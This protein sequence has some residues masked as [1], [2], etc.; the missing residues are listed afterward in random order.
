MLQTGH[1]SSQSIRTKQYAVS[2]STGLCQKAQ[3]KHSG[4]QLAKAS[5][6]HTQREPGVRKARHSHPGTRSAVTLNQFYA[7]GKAAHFGTAFFHLVPLAVECSLKV[8]RHGNIAAVAGSAALSE[9]SA[10]NGERGS[11]LIKR[12]TRQRYWHHSSLCFSCR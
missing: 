4:V 2:N 6:Q 10:H 1:P 5:I 8:F 12:G 11:D 9:Q 3:L 7:A